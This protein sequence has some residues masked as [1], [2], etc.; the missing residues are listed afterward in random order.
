MLIVDVD[1]TRLR[2]RVD[3]GYLDEMTDDLDDAVARVLAAKDVAH[4]RSRVGLVGNA[5]TVFPELLARGVAIDI[6]TDQTSAHDPLSYLPEGVIGRR[7]A[8]ARGIRP[9]GRSPSAPARRW[10]ST[11]EAM[12]ELPGRRR[13]GVRLRQ[14]DPPRGRARR[15]RPGVRVPRLRARLHPSAVRRGQGAV[16]LGGALGRPGRHRGDRPRHPRAVPRR[17]APAPLDHAGR[18]RRCTSRACPPAS[19]GSATRSAT[20]RA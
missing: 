14:L 12:V 16:P 18:A 17:R 1:A 11:C 5:A 4:G 10:P 9:R 8:R 15:L 19:A 7:V 20:S 6:V 2:R 13:R 3:H